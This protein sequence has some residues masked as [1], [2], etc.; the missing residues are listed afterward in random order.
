MTLVQRRCVLE[1]YIY[2]LEKLMLYAS[3]S[4]L[5]SLSKN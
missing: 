1:R 3:F 2:F 4:L 5:K